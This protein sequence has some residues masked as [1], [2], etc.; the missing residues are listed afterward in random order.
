MEGSPLGGTAV[1]ACGRRTIGIRCAAP[2]MSR[3]VPVL[4][5]NTDV[6]TVRKKRRSQR[7]MHRA[8]KPV[9]D[10]AAADELPIVNGSSGQEAP[11]CT[12]S[13]HFPRAG[14]PQDQRRPVQRHW[15][16]GRLLRRRSGPGAVLLSSKHNERCKAPSRGAH[17]P[18]EKHPEPKVSE[19]IYL[20]LRDCLQLDRDAKGGE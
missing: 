11:F 5:S 13:P 7:R 6:D 8:L 15:R 3:F 14:V 18:N 1:I 10:G 9:I 4:T 16:R 12:R 17:G 19:H 2:A 20:S